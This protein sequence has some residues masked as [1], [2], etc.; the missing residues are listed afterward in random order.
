MTA[1]LR[2]SRAIRGVIGIVTLAGALLLSGCSAPGS[3][4]TSTASAPLASSSATVP[5]TTTPTDASAGCTF[6]ASRQQ[7][8]PQQDDTAKVNEQKLLLVLTNSSSAEC[9]IGGYPAIALLDSAG[10]SVSYQSQHSAALPE[11]AFIV[12]PGGEAFILI[13]AYSQTF[14]PSCALSSATQLQVTAP[15]TIVPLVVDVS[16]RKLC[17]DSV[18]ALLYS[19]V[20]PTP[21]DKGS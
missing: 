9:E 16:D 18:G 6:A 13:D 4:P 3:T 14:F 17:D 20:S 12:P 19:A 8:D 5:P 10:Q 1:T 21:T 2:S 7:F 11:A 15:G